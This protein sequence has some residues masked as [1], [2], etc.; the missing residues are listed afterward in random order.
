MEN[1]IT[2]S[3]KCK[4][5]GQDFSYS[6]CTDLSAMMGD[7]EPTDKTDATVCRECASKPQ[8]QR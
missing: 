3:G 5:C 7:V 8:D 1:T 6:D 4:H 2:I